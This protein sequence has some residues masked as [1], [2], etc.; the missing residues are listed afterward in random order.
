MEQVDVVVIG[1]GLS[2][3]VAARELHRR[4][5]DVLVLEAADRPGGRALTE[6]TALGSRVDLGGQ[7]I[8]HGH[9]RVTELA[10][11]LGATP[12]RMHTGALPTVVDGG[13]ALPAVAPPVLVA[14]L[15]LAGI[16]V[17]TRSGV[18]R[19]AGDRTLRSLLDRVP[20]RTARRLLEVALSAA[21]TAD[22]DR[23]SIRAM[24]RM[25][26]SQGGLRTALGTRGGAQDSL[27]VEGMGTLVDGLAAALGPR[28]RLGERVVAVTDDGTGITVRT[29]TD[30]TGTVRAGRVVVT[31]PP[32]TAARIRFDPPLPPERAALGTDMY[33]GSVHKA[34]AVYERPFWRDR[35][36]A[37]LL[38]LDPPGRAVFDSG[39][40]DGPGHLCVLVAG[41]QAR[42]IDGLDPAERRER[43][44]GPLAAQLGKRVREPVDWREKSWHLDEHAGGGYLALPLPG[45]TDRFPPVP[46]APVGNVHWAG[47]ETSTEHPGYLEGAVASGLQV[48][49]E[50]HDRRT[51][52]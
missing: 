50:L 23:F 52:A 30:T 22:P 12:F 7:W 5:V 18:P 35:T 1:A 49:D 15:A 20:G 43:L 40:P 21:W 48:A 16:E 32:P 45:T 2:G 27:L 28:V 10:A 36:S 26:R 31:A 24:T 6:T 46:S 44:L 13:R 47:S 9:H 41:P 25:V 39:P 29:G 4:G 37:E 8:G 14:G 33:M 51:G 19:R 17:L 42:A 11:E 3:L 34:I 38:V